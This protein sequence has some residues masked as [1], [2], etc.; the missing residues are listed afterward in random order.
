MCEVQ[1]RSIHSGYSYAIFLSD[2][3][4]ATS[5]DDMKDML[6]SLPQFQEMRDKV[7]V[8]A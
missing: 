4:N 7:R 6:A 8:L 2:S 5:L 1:A 3:E